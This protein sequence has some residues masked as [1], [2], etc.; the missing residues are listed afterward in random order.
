MQNVADLLKY[1]LTIALSRPSQFRYV[2]LVSFVATC[3]G[4][5]CYALYVRRERG[6]LLHLDR[7]GLNRL[8]SRKTH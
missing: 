5:V 4:A 8:L 6:H 2:A 3:A 1:A 7:L